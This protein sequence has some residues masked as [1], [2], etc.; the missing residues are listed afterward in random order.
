M[1]FQLNT[2]DGDLLIVNGDFVVGD[3]TKQEVYD[4]LVSNPGDWLQFPNCG[5][6]L[7]SYQNGFTTGLDSVVRKQLTADGF[8]VK[9]LTITLDSSN[10]LVVTPV[11]NRG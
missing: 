8:T 9:K 11:V 1:D 7:E 3:T 5:C 6:S 4:I 10:K 2:L